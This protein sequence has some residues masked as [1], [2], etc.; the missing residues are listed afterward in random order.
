MNWYIG[1]LIVCVNNTGSDLERGKIYDIQML[2]KTPCSCGHIHIGVGVPITQSEQY[3][4]ICGHVF[5]AREM[6]LY[7]ECRFRPLQ[8]TS[9]EADMKEAIEESLCQPAAL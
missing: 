1:Q 4:A 6:S 3:C 9:E 2:Q 8:T 7:M 5:P